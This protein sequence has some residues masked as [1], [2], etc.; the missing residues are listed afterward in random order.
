VH[1]DLMKVALISNLP[2]SNIQDE[3]RYL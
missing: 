1:R 3:I 2:A